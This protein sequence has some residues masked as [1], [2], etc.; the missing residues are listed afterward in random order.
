LD[1]R[2]TENLARRTTY[3]VEITYPEN[4]IVVGYPRRG[5]LTLLGAY[6]ARGKELKMSLARADWEALGAPVVASYG[7]RWKLSA[8]VDSAAAN[9]HFAVNNVPL[10][11]SDAEGWVIRFDSGLRMKIKLADYVR[12]HGVLSRTNARTLWEALVSGSD[13]GDIFRTVPDEFSQ[14]VHEKIEDLRSRQ[15][16]WT[17]SAWGAYKHI[18]HIQDRKEFAL[19]AVGH[20][21]AAAL[22]RLKD[23]KSIEHL[24]WK[25]VQP[26]S[27]DEDFL[28]PAMRSPGETE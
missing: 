14:W 12:L 25:A 21:Y 4:R 24:A 11:G 28:P 27:D 1:L 10:R 13:I 22:F 15:I 19:H 2:P 8:I 7:T 17:A 5:T 16:L 6:D 20:P 23:G 9:R 18:E 3:L 26:T